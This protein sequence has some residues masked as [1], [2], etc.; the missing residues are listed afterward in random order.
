VAVHA[1]G[2]GKPLLY[3]HGAYGRMAPPTPLE[4]AL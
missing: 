3:A 1:G 2:A 4:V